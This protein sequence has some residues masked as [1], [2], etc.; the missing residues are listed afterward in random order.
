MI[1][2]RKFFS[3]FFSGNFKLVCETENFVIV[4]EIMD[5]RIVIANAYAPNVVSEK[6]FSSSSSSSW[7]LQML[8]K[9]CI[10]MVLY[11]VE[12]LTVL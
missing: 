6:T 12:I 7:N 9:T 8:Y 5:K 10:L 2:F 11:F 3:F 4:F 1:L